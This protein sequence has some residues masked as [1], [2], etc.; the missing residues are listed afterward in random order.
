[1]LWGSQKRKRKER[2]SERV[3]KGLFLTKFQ[4]LGTALAK[5][6][7]LVLQPVTRNRGEKVTWKRILMT[8]KGLIIAR[9][10]S[11]E[12]DPATATSRLEIFLPSAL[13]S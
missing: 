10:T 9:V 6:S 4:A 5:K 13:G 3:T 2:I 7:E 11:P 12:T 8:S 1:M